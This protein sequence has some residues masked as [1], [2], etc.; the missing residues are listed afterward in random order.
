MMMIRASMG[1]GMMGMPAMNPMMSMGMMNPMAMMMMRAAAGQVAAGVVQTEAQ[2]KDDIRAEGRK[3]KLLRDLDE[4]SAELEARAP[5]KRKGV[6]A[7]AEPSRP[8]SPAGRDDDRERGEDHRGGRSE[9]ASASSSTAAVSG[10]QDSAAAT[11]AAPEAPPEVPR[12]HL[13]PPKKPNAKCKFCQRA[14][15]AQ[16]QQQQG[17]KGAAGGDEGSK[18]AA[19]SSERSR[20]ESTEDYS[21]RTF[22]CSPMLK[23]QI[24]GSTYFKSLLSLSSLEELIEEIGRFADTLDVYNVGSMVSPSCFICQVYRLFTLPQAEDMEEVIEMLI[25]TSKAPV[26]RCAGLLYMRFVVT[27]SHLWEKMEEYLFD[28]ME[29]R[30]IEP[31]ETKPKWNTIGEYVEALL[32]S[33]KYFSTPLPR[34]PVKVRTHL[35]KECAPLSNYRKRM[36]ANLQTFRKLRVPSLPVEV[37]LDGHWS[38]GKAK[39]YAGRSRRKL[40][41]E[42]DDGKEVSVHLGKVVLREEEASDRSG[43]ASGSDAE[44]GRRRRSR[45]RRRGGKESSGERDWSRWKGKAEEDLLSELRERAKEEAVCG[46]GKV[47]A[48]RPFTVEEGL[49]R[50]EP[51]TRVSM[52]GD[53]GSGGGDSHRRVSSSAPKEKSEEEKRRSREEDEARQ[54]RQR[55]IFEKYGSSSKATASRTTTPGGLDLLAPDVLRLG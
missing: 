55:E 25:D 16:Q 14:L 17:A 48:R 33:D 53:D 30:I 10:T 22:N 21:R 49:W 27:A 44:D 41:V 1:M 36:A 8:R 40:V 5:E 50:K 52:L 43:S 3:E 47:Y 35:E 38:P 6:F 26:V 54:R 23:D 39:E 32:V 28:D 15:A 51:E 45:S 37:C 42:L 46:H 4:A 24:F 9:R 20:E 34:L 2:K 29:I 18:A 12:C 7:D 19:S 31:R 11:A 13:H